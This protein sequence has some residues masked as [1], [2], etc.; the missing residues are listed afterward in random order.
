MDGVYDEKH[1]RFSGDRIDE[2]FLA[3]PIA[4]A[5]AYYRITDTRSRLP[6]GYLAEM[7]HLMAI[8]LSTVAPLYAA[9]GAGDGVSALSN[10]EIEKLLFRTLKSGG[11]PNLENLRVRKADLER[12]IETLRASKD[13]FWEKH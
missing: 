2:E 11:H 7:V 1:R 13:A 10:H 9:R 3:L 8:A 12:G 4:A 5:V 6:E